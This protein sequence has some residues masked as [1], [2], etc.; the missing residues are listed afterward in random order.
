VGSAF[1]WF[2][3]QNSLSQSLL[4]SQS[5]FFI[6]LIQLQLIILPLLIDKNSLSDTKIDSLYEPTESGFRMSGKLAR[7]DLQ[8]GHGTAYDNTDTH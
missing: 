2:V 8:H 3:R 4:H 1:D 6:R 5:I 7:C